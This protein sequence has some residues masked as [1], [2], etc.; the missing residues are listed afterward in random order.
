MD[1]LHQAFLR[2]FDILLA[3]RHDLIDQAHA[4][5]HQIYCIENPFEPPQPGARERDA[6]DRRSVH[7]LV[8][9][10]DTGHAVG[11]VR[12]V[13]PDRAKPDAPFPLEV[14]CGQRLGRFPGDAWEV[15]RRSTA[16]I[17]RFAVSKQVSERISTPK[18]R[19]MEPQHHFRP[20]I[21]MGLFAAIVRMSARHGVTHWFAMMEP[22]LLRLLT[23]FG[24]HF[25]VIGPTVEHRGGRVP[26]LASVE[27]LL[28]RMLRERPDVW[29]LA[30]G[31]GQIRP[32]VCMDPEPALAT[33]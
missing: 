9:H 1:K 30:T 5:R 23:R 28:G 26:A 15:P 29:A 2:H 20:H 12:L 19:T 31:E 17:S 27:D 7:S 33:S 4:L 6:W 22:T 16:E 8:R 21:T 18:C 25:Q 14:C 32:A 10:R 3:D 13:L 11:V 24:V